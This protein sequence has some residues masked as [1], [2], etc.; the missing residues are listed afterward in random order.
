[1]ILINV[2]MALASLK[3][4]KIRSF[5]TMLG[6]VI[7]VA[8]VVIIVGLG[9][10]VK[11]QVVEQ[12]NQYGTDTIVVRSGKTFIQDESGAI[13]NI[14]LNAQSATSTLS[15]KDVESLQK[16]EEVSV[17]APAARIDGSLSSFEVET[18]QNANIIATTGA[19]EQVLKQQLEY[20]EFFKDNNG[21]QNTAVI[22]SS[23]ASGLFNQSDPIGRVFS[24]RDQDFTVRGVLAPSQNGLVNIGTDI[25]QSVYIPINAAQNVIGVQPTISEIIIKLND[26]ADAQIATK[27]VKET[28]L[29]NR[30]GE[31]DFT[32]LSQDEYLSIAN[33]VFTVLTTFVAAIAAISLVVGGIGIMNIMLVS[34]S[35]RTREIGVRKAIGATNQQILG[36]FLVEATVISMIGGVLGVFVSLLAS[37]F[38]RIGTD[39]RPVISLETIGIA[40]C[41]SIIVGIV[42]GMAPAIQ[43]ARKDP[44]QALR[45][46]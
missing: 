46:E 29:A 35:E 14:N 37:Y 7:G 30:N 18:Y 39:I 27:S 36:Q 23:I 22:G 19:V 8:S 32:I 5:L 25:N 3:S 6:V 10:G 44:I 16:M 24:I 33:R 12:I 43:A 9:E 42:F 4:A 21:L 40:V 26:G 13:K 31:E 34:V 2:K 38:I 41:V 1:M 15:Q 17:V 28:L 11:K 45:H 20:G